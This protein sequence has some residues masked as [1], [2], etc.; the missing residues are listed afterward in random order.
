MHDFNTN[1]EDG[2]NASFD[3]RTNAK[4]GAK[5]INFN[6]NTHG[7]TNVLIDDSVIDAAKAKVIKQLSNIY[8]RTRLKKYTLP[9]AVEI[10]EVSIKKLRSMVLNIEQRMAWY[11]GIDDHRFVKCTILNT[12]TES[13]ENG[14]Y[15]CI[16]NLTVDHDGTRFKASM[17]LY[18]LNIIIA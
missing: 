8:K 17:P 6:I 12:N 1:A 15:N 7:N 11:V 13:D 18:N 16:A 2:N 5:T 10:Q 14:L 9:E 4:S 3:L